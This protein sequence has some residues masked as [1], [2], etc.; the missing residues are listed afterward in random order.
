MRYLR[1]LFILAL[2]FP[3]KSLYGQSSITVI[4]ASSTPGLAAGADAAIPEEMS[5]LMYASWEKFLEGYNHIQN[6]DA[7]TARMFFDVAVD[8]LLSSGWVI[9][10]TPPLDV[11]FNDLTQQIRDIESDYFFSLYDEDA[12]EWETAYGD[13]TPDVDAFADLD[14]DVALDD[15]ALRIAL[16]NG[17]RQSSFDIPIDVNNHVAKSLEFFLNKGR[18]FFEDALMR[19]G[20]YRPLIEQIFREEELPLDLVNLALVESAFK[21]QAISRAKARGMWQFIQGTAVRSGLKITSDI[22]ERSDPEKSTR[23]A[24]RYLKDL[25]AMFNDWNLAL[26]AYNWGEGNV[27][28]LIEKTGITDFWQLAD[29]PKAI[30]AETRKHVPLILAAAILSRNPEKYGF[31]T[32]F[33]PPM[34]YATVVVSK[35]VDLRSIAKA[36]NTSVDELKKLNPALKGSRT[37]SRYPNF[38]L[39]VPADSDPELFALV[40]KLPAA[41]IVTVDGKHKV[42]Q[43][44]TLYDLARKYGVS[45]NDL[46]DV[47]G[48]TSKSILSIGVLLEIPAS[49]KK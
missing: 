11:Y 33:E 32:E 2:V 10:L 43:G 24:A 17:F 15:P 21:P 18:K 16:G 9:S 46:Q 40:E 4:T 28:R 30:P 23:A 31:S 27:R 13:Y 6:G 3:W 26:A 22:D 14:L 41:K 5:D 48:L 29:R 25:Y 12:D 19:S 36:L 7:D 45:L 37:P 38:V 8:M 44:D 35:P 20:R 49:A 39:K 34:S 47:N 1:L 42:E